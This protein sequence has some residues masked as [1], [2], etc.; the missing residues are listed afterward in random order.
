MLGSMFLG[1][2]LLPYIVLAMGAAM[3]IGTAFALVRPPENRRDDN[4]LDRAPLIRSL[5]L[6]AA[7]TLA[8]VWALASLLT[9]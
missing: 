9:G 1:D 3:A 2:N 7:G 8:A 5:V 4:D 6:I